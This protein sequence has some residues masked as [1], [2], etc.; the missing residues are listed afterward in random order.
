LGKTLF[1]GWSSRGLPTTT[2]FQSCDLLT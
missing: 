1:A 2:E